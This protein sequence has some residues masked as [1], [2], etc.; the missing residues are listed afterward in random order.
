MK[1]FGLI[2]AGLLSILL[3]SPALTS[4]GALRIR[5]PRTPWPAAR[6]AASDSQPLTAQASFRRWQQGQPSHWRAFLLHP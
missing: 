2:G 4:D 3:S 6:Q 1:R 5:L